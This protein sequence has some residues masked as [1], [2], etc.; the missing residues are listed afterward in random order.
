[1]KAA[2][3]SVLCTAILI[4]LVFSFQL[5]ASVS[6]DPIGLAVSLENDEEMEVEVI[7]TNETEVDLEYLIRMTPVEG[8][9][10]RR[11][12][13]RRDDLGDEI[14]EHEV[15]N[16]FWTGLAWDGDLMWGVDLE[17]NVIASYDPDEGEMGDP[18]NINGQYFGMAFDGGAFWMGQ[19][20]DNE[21]G[22]VRRID[23]DGEVL[24]TLNILGWIAFGVAWDGE[25]I[26][27]YALDPD[28]RPSTLR[29][30]SVQGQN[31]RSVDISDLVQGN[32]ASITWVP[33]HEEGHLWLLVQGEDGTTLFQLNV[34]E[35]EAEVI[36]Q[37]NIQRANIFGLDHD[38][39]N[40]WHPIQGAAWYEIDDDIMEPRWLTIDPMEGLIESEGDVQI[41]FTFTP[42]ELEDGVYEM[43]VSIELSEPGD[44]ENEP[45]PEVIELSAVMSLEVDVASIAGSVTAVA[46][47]APVDNARIDLDAYII[48]RFTDGEG[49][50]S[51]Q[52]LPLGDYE[53]MVTAPDF[54]PAQGEISLDEAGEYD[55]NF[56]LNHA[57]CNPSLQAIS[58]DVSPD[59]ETLVVFNVDNDG[60][61][62]LGYTVERRLTGDAA[63]DPWTLREDH[64]VGA[65]LEDTYI[66]GVVF[67]DD[68][69][70]VSGA[71]D[72]EPVIYIIDRNGE[73]S[74]TFDQPGDD[75]RGMR[76]LAYDGRY[77]WGSI[78]NTVYGMTAGGEVVYE[79]RSPYNPTNVLTWD[80]DRE[81][82]WL[83]STTTNPLAFTRDGEP[84]EDMEINRN[85]LRIYGL[86]YWQEDPDGYPL[87]AYFKERDTDRPGLSK[88]NPDEDDMQFV[89]YLENEA[90]DS[91]MG[92][93][94]SSELDI[95]SW[96]FISIVNQTTE[97]GGDR[98][99]IWQIDGRK[100]WM[101]LDV[102][103]GV[104]GA[105]ESQQFELVLNSAGLPPE[106]FE[107]ELYF[108][109][110]GI[111]GET[112][113][114]VTMNIVEGPVQA[115]FTLQLTMGWS[116]VSVYLQPDEEDVVVLT[117]D[118]VEEDLLMMMKDGFGNFYSPAD[119]FS[120][121]P[122]W[123]VAQGY[124]FK[125][126]E[127]AE[128]I[129]EG[130]TVMPD[131]PIDLSSGW[132]MTAYYMRDE[133]DAIVALSG[134][135][136]HLLIAK[137]GD[138][139]FYIPAWDF[140]NMGNMAP[141]KGY[142][143][144]LDEDT[145][146]VYRSEEVD[147]ELASIRWNW[148]S[149]TGSAYKSRVVNTGNNMS[150]LVLSPGEFRGT[151]NV[152]AGDLLVGSGESVSGACGIAVWGDD[153]STS[154]IDGAVSGQ[155]LRIT[156]DND[157]IPLEIQDISGSGIYQVD[158][159]WIARLGGISAPAEYALNSVYPNPFNSRSV[160]TFS[161]PEQ[162]K[163]SLTVHD[164]AGRL[165]Q[166]L[167]EDVFPSG[168][169]NITW[170]ASQSA[171]G[172]YI[173]RL[174]TEKF[175]ASQKVIL[176]R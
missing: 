67:F 24:A 159:L 142:Q 20:Q 160:I 90:G 109:H 74:G 82:L 25:N 138:G 27:Y 112:A 127:A 85:D 172:M 37:C 153:E 119:D 30:M 145:E 5:S 146:L 147:D 121:I 92:A 114:P 3:G 174:D 101:Q 68:H 130:V 38:G 88:F 105:G 35:D 163:L 48:T 55:L 80:S 93:Y 61:G 134:I 124:Q 137:D 66:N 156:I 97:L 63:A 148:S 22:V 70:Y 162:A 77:I 52:D 10:E 34:Q 120:N 53:L 91:P 2:L 39:E 173:I 45:E 161:L 125:M 95:Y 16:G 139:N 13:P 69:Y 84:F 89:T 158:G 94:I 59:S 150:L 72:E 17:R 113:I 8:D 99:D 57:E 165:V 103:G 29:Q 58:R 28:G 157:E 152:F 154:V 46:G 21:Q 144:K 96:V 71:N 60:N 18:V 26:W 54:L 122:G 44:D 167:T 15:A 170:D 110:D 78:G 168:R 49:E 83:G 126:R 117:R 129:L 100:D 43:L 118:L 115:E 47:D 87:Y 86:A 7:M 11:R 51:F 171:A 19:L 176:L 128:L 64:A 36:Q 81:V 111:G 151:I 141:G 133:V 33:E 76:D 155:P 164:L 98:I 132:N 169:H 41:F 4:I 73:L 108:S 116:L 31:L 140:S 40:L 9:E 75:R 123:D 50:Y 65:A 149:K 14:A 136:E 107:G 79:W 56:Q 104:I 62:P 106:R 131:E 23:R 166:T 1:M 135:R 12:G 6:I 32:I 175:N 42:E 143:L 102:E